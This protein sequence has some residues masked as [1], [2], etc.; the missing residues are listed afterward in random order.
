MRGRSLLLAM[1]LST[2]ALP[3]CGA[4]GHAVQRTSSEV[5]GIRFLETRLQPW[6][7]AESPGRL[8]I[9]EPATGRMVIANAGHNHN[10]AATRVQ[11][12]DRSARWAAALA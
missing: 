8:A 4:Q 5:S 6:P 7:N 3:S 9:T 12:W 2:A 11:L 1:A 10:V